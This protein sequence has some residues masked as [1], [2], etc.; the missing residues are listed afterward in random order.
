MAIC[1]KSVAFNLDKDIPPLNGKVILVM[2]GN[3]GLGKQCVLEFA[4]HNPH[5]IQLASRNLDKA[6]AAADEIRAQVP[7]APIK[8]L[9]L[10]LTSF[11][12]VK[13][14]ASTVLSASSRLDILMLNAGIMAI[15][16]GLTSSGYELQFGTNHMGHALLT[17][18]LLPLLT[19]TAAADAD[20]RV[21]SLSSH[22]HVYLPRGG[23]RFDS[24]RTTAD[25]MGAYW[26][27]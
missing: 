12:S 6:K 2:G 20:V 26:R 16:P 22:G 8:I 27:Y 4:R 9:E 25:S 18:L 19:N 1:S 10:D 11:D 13:R 5:Q 17:K 23:F 21:V 24:L 14:A 15:P 3:I 7:D